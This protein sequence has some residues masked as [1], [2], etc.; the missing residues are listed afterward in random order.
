VDFKGR[1]MIV[2]RDQVL[3]AAMRVAHIKLR[4]FL[5]GKATIGFETQSKLFRRAFVPY[6]WIKMTKRLEARGVHI[7]EE[8]SDGLRLSDE[9]RKQVFLSVIR[10]A[11]IKSI[12]YLDGVNGQ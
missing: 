6:A 4:K 11:I 9:R 10:N 8:V 1:G 12:E 2:Y 3:C 5:Q 7:S